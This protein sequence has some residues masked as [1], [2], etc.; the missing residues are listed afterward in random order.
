MRIDG[1]THSIYDL[2]TNATLKW[3]GATVDERNPLLGGVW[4][5]EV[6]EMNFRKALRM[7]SISMRPSEWRGVKADCRSFVRPGRSD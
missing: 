3:N 2:R 5:H 1:Q 7:K 6:M 4:T